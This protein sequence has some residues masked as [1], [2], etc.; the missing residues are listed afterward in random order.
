M[1]WQANNPDGLETLQKTNPVAFWTLY[2]AEYGELPD[3]VTMPGAA[4]DN[5]ATLQAAFVVV[6]NNILGR[7]SWTWMDWQQNDPDRLEAMA[8]NSPAAFNELY[9]AEY[10]IYPHEER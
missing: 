3:G 9:K 8:K 6:E 10:G 1:D 2:K 4:N 7:S 5:A